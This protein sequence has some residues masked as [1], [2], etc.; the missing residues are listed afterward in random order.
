MTSVSPSRETI[1]ACLIVMNEAERLQDALSSVSF[2][3]EVIVV[4]GGSTDGTQR[5]AAAM[6][7]RV[8]ENPWPGYARQ[9]NVA[10]DHAGSEWILE[11]D[12]DER[13]S[14]ELRREIEVFLQ[15]PP[16]HLD[17]ATIPLR[18][19]FIG[20]TL[21]PS[22]KYPRYR[23][24]LFRRS[25]YRHDERR[26]VH[27]GLYPRGEVWP[28]K[29][30][31]VH[32]LAEDW[33]EAFDDSVGYARLEAQHRT[34]PGVGELVKGALL[35]PPVKFAYRSFALGGWHDGIRGIAWITAECMSDALASV[36]SVRSR[37]IQTIPGPEKA[38]RTGSV[39][40]V[41]LAATRRG[42]EHGARWLTEAER[43]GA[44]VA[45][46]AAHEPETGIRVQRLPHFGPL[47]TLRAL[48]VESQVRPV[49]GLVVHDRVAWLLGLVPP[50]RG[51]PRRVR[52]FGAI[53]NA[54]QVVREIVRGARSALSHEVTSQ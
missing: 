44:D 31:L 21:G 3:D 27:E 50:Q 52:A 1:S 43:A 19:T 15:G 25:R 14:D 45:L 41:G 40:I 11:I 4:D 20:R 37:A 2:C 28:M 29:H 46:I 22:A 33:R 39:R 34:R 49:D 47:E 30:D 48:E 9:R 35:R 8:V 6:G 26:L 24:R 51:Y 13:V 16:K 5:V 42:A 36:F 53:P 17:M 54:E 38:V 23:N 12:A 18:D 7:A 32:L 10:A